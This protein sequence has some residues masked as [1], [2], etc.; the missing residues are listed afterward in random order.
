MIAWVRDGLIEEDDARISIHDAGLLQADGVFETALLHEGG[1]FRLRAH[2]RRLAASAAIMRLPCPDADR[3][4]FI[5]REVVRANQ[6]SNA[7]LRITLTRGDREHGPGLIV[8]ARLPDGDWIRRAREGWRLVTAATTRPDVSSIPAELKALGRT[9]A[10]LARHEAADAGVDDA[11]LLTGR[12]MVCEG[13]SWNVFWRVGTALYT[14]A[15]E[16]GVLS[17]VTR[18]LVI[19]LA[20]SEGIPVCQGAYPRADLDGADEI[21]ATMT[22]VGI[23]SIRELDGRVLP[24]APEYA[25]LILP[26]Y[27]E[28]LDRECAD[29]YREARARE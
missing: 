13:P 12:G 26:L 6:L 1:F 7:S 23:V 10:I 8:A 2:L 28:V 3:L 11:L 5:A 29:D 21:F 4:E 19:Q 20:E 18:S 14:P 9:Y 27:A 22:S 17:G 16:V 25:P 24:T 15:L